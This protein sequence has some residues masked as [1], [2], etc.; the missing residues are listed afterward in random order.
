MKAG[1]KL[2]EVKKVLKDNNCEA[3]MIENCGMENEKMYHSTDE[4][5]DQG[6]YYSLTIVKEKTK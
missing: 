2:N 3:V 4:I 6:S 1:S 5:P